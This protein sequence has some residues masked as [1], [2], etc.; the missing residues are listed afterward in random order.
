MTINTLVTADIYEAEKLAALPV[1]EWKF[2]RSDSGNAELFARMF[3]NLF[4]F[5]MRRKKW[6]VFDQHTFR[7]DDTNEAF[8]ATKLVCDEIVKLSLKEEE[9]RDEILKWSIASRSR[10]KRE[11]M[12]AIAATESSLVL[13][14]SEWDLDPDLVGCKNGVLNL[15]T[16]E[17]RTGRP[18]DLISRKLGPAFDPSANCPRFERFMLEIF[19]GD[20]E[21]IEYVQRQSGYSL[22]G[23]VTQQDIRIEVGVG[24][25]GKGQKQRVG[26]AIAGDYGWVLPFHSLLKKDRN[27][28][29]VPN[30][31][32]SLDGRRYVAL[33]EASEGEVLNEGRVKSLTGDDQLSARYLHAEFFTFKPTFKL[34]LSLNDEPRITDS[35]VAMWDRV[36]KIPYHVQFGDNEGQKPRDNSLNETLM[37]ELPGI[38]NWFLTGAIRWYADGMAEPDVVKIATLEL[39]NE[40]DRLAAFVDENLVSATNATLRA[41]QA[42]R[43]YETWAE[44]NGITGYDRLKS[45]S[46]GTE[47]GKRFKRRRDRS[48]QFYIGVGFLTEKDSNVTDR[49]SI[50]DSQTMF[51]GSQTLIDAPDVTDELNSGDGSDGKPEVIPSK[52]SHVEKP[53]KKPS[54]PLQASQPLKT[55][56]AVNGHSRTKSWLQANPNTGELE[57]VVLL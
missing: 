9:K 26:L 40:N 16:G 34:W 35:S 14:G 32:A 28:S 6:F 37:A 43:A 57:D 2:T 10:S 39:K 48:G 24:R 27:S 55:S 5:D 45:R 50:L 53:L 31:I 30:D 22:T 19:D 56:G 4:R 29:G 33:S 54:H 1:D 42:F 13:S 46:F 17:F 47:L 49:S 52:S 21:L 8:R 25:N 38:L 11:A 23:H 7:P 41:G 36:K 51:S 3:R 15:K 18:E 44:S 12:L 20:I